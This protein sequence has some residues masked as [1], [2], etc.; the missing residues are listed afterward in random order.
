M[1]T[2]SIRV[3]AA[4]VA[5]IA[6]LTL[7]I[8]NV[9]AASSSVECGQ[10]TGYTAP[11]PSGPTDGSL[12]IGLLTPWVILADATVSADATTSLPSIVNNSPTCVALDFDDGGAIT[13]V[14]FAPEGVVSGTV[15]FDSGS[16]FYLFAGRMIVPDF[17]TDAYP[18]IAALFVTSYQ[19]GTDLTVTFTVDPTTG[20]FVGFDGHAAFCG[21]GGVD[22]NGDGRVGDAVIPAEV[23]DAED[24]AA[25]EGAGKHRTCAAIH[26]SGTIDPDD[27]SIVTTT[28]VVIT[29]AG[30]GATTVPTAPPT[31]IADPVTPRANDRGTLTAVLFMIFGA[32]A[33]LSIGRFGRFGRER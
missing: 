32:G 14:D 17:V 21:K 5:C 8:A 13:S 20:Q 26:S 4:L 31:S 33:L 9:A 1:R 30:S 12:Q 27:G 6:S 10:L 2:S 28:D 25:L 24:L 22:S 7:G 19:A 23:L 15:T 29:V 11:D 18:G 3:S 16:G